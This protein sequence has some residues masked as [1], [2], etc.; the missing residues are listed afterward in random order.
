V[1]PLRLG[2][3]GANPAR[4]WFRDAHVPALRAVTGFVIHAVSARDQATANA[5]A[6]ALRAP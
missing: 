3:A 4:G 6:E 5:A 1:K 2:I